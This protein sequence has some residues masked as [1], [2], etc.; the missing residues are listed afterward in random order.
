M[1]VGGNIRL[2]LQDLQPGSRYASF[3]YCFNYFQ[4]FR[5]NGC[6][7]SLAD[8]ANM[9]LSCLQL[10]FFLASWGMYHNS[11]LLQKSV[12]VYEPLICYIAKADCALWQI[13]VGSYNVGDN[14]DRLM[15]SKSMIKKS[16]S[17]GGN[18]SDTL[19]T[20]IML[21][22]FGNVPAF[23]TYFEK[24]LKIFGKGV[25]SLHKVA[26]FY[27]DESNQAIIDAAVDKYN[28]RTWDFASRKKTCRKYTKA[29]VIDMVG[30]IE[31]QSLKPKAAD[32]VRPDAHH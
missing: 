25:K 2:Y 29:K 30:F 6:L 24:G 5:E 17:K 22:V 8:P 21:G 19:V 7:E 9:Q 13:D 10:G 1:D 18:A 14:V 15:K 20:K 27:N 16:L 3:D 23:D 26:E 31:G 12:A 28:L 32:G 11:F 4:S